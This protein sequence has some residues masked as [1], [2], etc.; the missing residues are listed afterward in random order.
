MK[1]QRG[2]G[3]ARCRD[4]R[5]YRGFFL[6]VE[7]PLGLHGHCLQTVWSRAH[8]VRNSD[9]SVRSIDAAVHD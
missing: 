5:D 8:E 6:A 9:K 3:P 1:A 7:P 2:S 4:Y